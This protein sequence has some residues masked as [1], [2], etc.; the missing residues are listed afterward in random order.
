MAENWYLVLEL[1]FDPPVEDEARIAARIEE[2]AKYWAGQFNHFKYGP[3]YRAYHQALPQIKK[4][5]IGPDNIRKQLAE[6][7]CKQTYGAVDERLKTI[8]R[9][10]SIREDEGEKLAQKLK[11]TVDVVKK[12]AAKLGIK[13]EKGPDVNYQAVYD[14]YYKTKPQNFDA[15]DVKKQMLASFGVNNLYD[16]LFLGTSIKFSDRQN[17]TCDTL[18][19]KAREQK[20]TRYSKT[21]SVS[22]TG[23]KLCGDCELAFKDEASKKG[24]DEYL[25]YVRRKTILDRIKEDAEITGELAAESAEEY[26]RRLTEVFR[27]RKLAVEVLTAFCKVERIPFNEGTKK[28]NHNLK[29]CRCGCINDV[30]DGRKVCQ[31]CGLELV[32]RCPKCGAENDASVR[33]CKCGF[34]FA[35]IDKAQS[36]CA[37]AELSM[38]ALEFPVAKA[39]LE[40]AERFWPG[41]SRVAELRRRL[42]D[43]EKRVGA[44]VS[45]L[46]EAMKGKRFFEARQQYQQI[47]KLFTGYADQEMEQAVNRAITEAQNLFRQAQAARA[48]KDVLELCARAYDVC[49]DLPGVRELM[50]KYPPSPATGFAVSVNPNTRVNTVSWNTD[51][52]DKSIRYVVVRSD[53]GWVQHMADGTAIYR[54]SASSYADKD[55]EPGRPYYYNVF[56]ERAGICSKGASGKI[57]EVVNL[58]EIG[59]VTAA[60][61]N[62]SLQLNWG[63]LPKNAVAEIYQITGTGERLVATSGS[64]GHLLTGL[65]NDQL[66]RYR[67]ALAYQVGGKKLTTR[68][69]VLSGT[70]TCPPDPI[71]TLRVKPLSGDQYQASWL[72]VG[73]GD[74]RLFG[75]TRKPGY[76]VGDVVALAALEKQMQQLQMTRPDTGSANGGERVCGFRYGGGELLYVAAVVVKAGSAVFGNLAR[77]CKDASVNIKSVR[78]INGKIHVFLDPPKDATG[79]VVLIRHDKFPT[80][81][82]DRQTVRAAVSIKQYEYNSA[83]V[84]DSVESKRY[85]F[86]VFAEFRRDGERDYSPGAD[87]LFDNSPK[88]NITYTVS[89][90]K[91]LFGA[92]TLVL[93]FR[94]DEKNFTLPDLDIV[95]KVG[96]APVFKAAGDLFHSIPGQSVEGSLAVRIPMN[97]LGKNTYIKV[98]FH[99]EADSANCQIRLAP[100]SKYQIT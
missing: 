73:S 19:E 46:R 41:S 55:I 35:N 39:R 44:E 60:P 5:M 96:S 47:R 65:T 14:K 86:S 42:S 77:A 25:E 12:R 36:M 95:S 57:E 51:P 74:V 6:E 21:D 80:G 20:K 87:Y 59:S 26:I 52:R 4:D 13:W 85:F 28:E 1:E 91:P 66:C 69:V 11:V 84:I 90:Q 72:D 53:S 61:G 71:D 54:G 78:I 97:S 88:A 63:L 81:L 56:A 68:G 99:S 58:F 34:P 48:E 70:P 7:A 43:Y 64:D 93:E 98:F 8:G 89:V 82:E 50:A 29:V 75:S 10:G 31:S 49:A 3:Q 83:I 94:A 79:F 15:Y 67:V 22:G 33:V 17:S 23:S 76:K 18:R 27:D 16:F 92:K 37:M 62:G 45:K 30:S 32:I 38:D 100:G 9:K 24:Y 2:K 40:D